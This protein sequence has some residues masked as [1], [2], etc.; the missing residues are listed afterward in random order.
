MQ[1]YKLQAAKATER[2]V[3]K[4]KEAEKRL[5][6]VSGESTAQKIKRKTAFSNQQILDTLF[7][8]QLEKKTS[9]LTVKT[10]QVDFSLNR[11][12][13]KLCKLPGKEMKDTEF[14]LINKLNFPG[15]WVL[16][17]KRTITLLNPYRMEEVL[18]YKRLVNSYKIPSQNLDSPIVLT[19]R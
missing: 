4:P 10:I 1:R 9:V 13:Q 12:K 19:F 6:L 3:Q 14:T 16:A 8:S 5:R 17:S 11:L 2:S 7:Q 15:A 18:L